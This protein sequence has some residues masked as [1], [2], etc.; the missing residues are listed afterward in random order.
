MTIET[1]QAQVHNRCAFC[2]GG[3]SVWRKW[4]MLSGSFGLAVFMQVGC[5]DEQGF[6]WLAFLNQPYLNTMSRHHYSN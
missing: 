6:S 2:T 4:Q 1:I 3:L 5:V